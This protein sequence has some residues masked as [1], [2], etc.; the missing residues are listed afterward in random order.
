[1]K[2]FFYSVPSNVHVIL[3]GTF[4]AACL[5]DVMIELYRRNIWNDAKTVNVIKEALFSKF[6]KVCWNCLT[7]QLQAQVQKTVYGGCSASALLM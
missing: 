7:G 4:E 3:T 1:M 6:T 2:I 5:Q